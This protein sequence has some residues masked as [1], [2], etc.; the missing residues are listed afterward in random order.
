MGPTDSAGAVSDTVVYELD[1]VVTTGT[2]Y[3]KKIIDIPYSVQRL[4]NTQF[5]Y[6]RKAGVNDVLESVPG[7]F[8]QSRYGNHDVRISIRGFGSRSNSGIRGVRILLDDIPESEPDGQT[9]IEAIDF[10][11]VG[12]IEVVKGNLSS[13][14][15]NSPGGVVN[16]I[17]DIYFPESFAVNFND[18]GSFDLRR[19]GIK[20]GIRTKDYAFL[21]T[22]SYHH[23]KGFREH[24]EDYW[25]I[26]NTVL[27]TTPNNSTNLQV[28]GYFVDGLI[29]LPGSLTK[30][31]FEED[32]FQAGQR[33]KDFDFRRVSK[34][35]R[36]GIRFSARLDR[37]ENN[38]IQLT[39]YSTIK[40]FE[41][42]SG[43]YRIINRYGLGA[44]ARYLNRSRIGGRNNEFTVGGDLL[45]QTGPIERYQNIAGNKGDIL[46][47]LNNNSI[48]NV[49]GYFL[50]TYDL[51]DN[52]FSFL[53]SGRYDKIVF[54]QKN[55]LLSSQNEK[56]RF[57]SFT[58]KLALNYKLTPAIALY[59]S[60]ATSFVSP[61]SN[62]LD[63]PPTSSDPSKLINPDI[64]AQESKNFEIGIKGQWKNPHAT[65]FK[66]LSLETTLYHYNI[67][68]EIVPAFEFLGEVFFANAAKSTRNGLEI[69]G[70]L[71]VTNGLSFNAAYTFS[72]FIYDEY[73]T[74]RVRVS[75]QGQL[76]TSLA[77]FSGNIPPS[78]PRHNIFLALTYEHPFFRNVNGF[79]KARHYN[80]SG[81]YVDDANTDKTDGYQL[82]NASAGCEINFTKFNM[83]V[84]GGVNNL[85]GSALCRLC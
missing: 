18:F 50:N 62:E 5:K 12:R 63:N 16:F 20:T 29:R 72:D 11:S 19:N 70:L 35:G 9:R 8:L 64:E 14:Y 74:T 28:L 38:E 83:Q 22:Y 41:R 33:E 10:N 71:E 13:L 85:A 40:Y 42:P 84:S 76:E 4:D 57:E 77:D 44:T 31:E 3:E 48:S 58:P 43:T 53:F 69:G 27:E 46:L 65:T 67:D 68:K 52:K 21:F 37:E 81:L 17:N 36:V 51:I 45:F 54:D 82:F 49:G 66:S 6:A 34:K 56:R 78:I 32:P 39:T 15:N 60:Y 47:T 30:E 79:L 1:A 59:S 26:V 23:Y 80:V 61:A 2:R 24:S 7:I 55:Q 75:D 73:T 25:H